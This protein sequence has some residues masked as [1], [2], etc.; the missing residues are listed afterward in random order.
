MAV[1]SVDE[2]EVDACSCSSIALCGLSSSSGCIGE[3]LPSV[4]ISFFDGEDLGAADL[5]SSSHSALSFFNL[6][7]VVSI[8]CRLLVD[9][10]F[11]SPF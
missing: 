5:I 6:A 7:N 3:R 10:A 4:S 1:G 8:V 11:Y 2:C 9:G